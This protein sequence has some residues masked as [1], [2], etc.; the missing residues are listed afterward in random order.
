MN[1]Q[2]QSLEAIQDIRRLM[3]RSSRFLSLSGLS[4]IAAGAWALI[5]AWAAARRI[6]SYYD[7]YNRNG[8]SLSEFVL[9]KQHLLLIAAAV[10]GL[11]MASAFFFTWR[12]AR[13]QG[14]PIW[15]RTARQ[16]SINMMI[17][18]VSGAVLLLALL[19]YEDA[20]MLGFIAPLCLV[21]YGLSLVNASKYTVNDIRYLGLLEI[22]LGLINTQ[23]LG[24]GLFFWA[25]GFGLLHIVYGFIMWWKNE[26]GDKGA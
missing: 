13:R 23:Y 24:Y 5:G 19:R 25:L 2:T 12:R 4:G 6:G 10:L 14:L 9:L 16:L 18:L 11:A 22:V 17:P 3:N 7:D 21:F 26:R 1:E 20:N 15:D 8:Y